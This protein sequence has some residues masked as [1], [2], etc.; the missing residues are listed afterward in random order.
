[1]KRLLQ[2]I[3]ISIFFLS[4][5]SC[6]EGLSTIEKMY[7]KGNYE[8]AISELNAYLF[9]HVTDVKAL[10]IRARSYEEL[11]N[12]EKA[13]SDFE[14]I[15]DLDSEYAQA[16]AGL[17]KILFEEKKYKEAELYLLRAAT[18]DYEDFDIL[19]LVGRTHLMLE[20]YESAENFLEMAKDLNP[21]FA[22]VYYYQGMAR[23]L[24]GDVLGCAASFNS[25]VQLEPD[26][27]VG[28]YNRGFALMKAGYIEWALDDFEAVLKTNPNHIEALAKKGYCMAILGDTEG[29]QILQLAASKGSEYA[30][31][32]AEV[33]I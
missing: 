8:E 31:N 6:S 20:K 2:T 22:K 25:Y 7:E 3:T 26:H 5:S 19:Y 24:R 17:G 11:G 18:L 14:R 23:A 1:M 15:I 9:F 13:R 27:T 12:I 4:A 30:K 16:F 32:Q 29:C 28:K 21:K 33:C 10:H